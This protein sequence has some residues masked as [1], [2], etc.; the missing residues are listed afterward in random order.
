MTKLCRCAPPLLLAALCSRTAHADGLSAP[1]LAV[2]DGYSSPHF[3]HV[4]LIGGS[5]GV[6][7]AFTAGPAFEYVTYN[8]NGQSLEVGAGARFHVIEP[9]QLYAAAGGIL[10]PLYRPEG[11]GRVTAGLSAQFGNAFFVRPGAAISFGLIGV[12][13]PPT[14]FLPMEA[15]VE[16]GYLFSVFSIYARIAGGLDALQKTTSPTFGR[17]AAGIGI[18]FPIP[19]LEVTT[20]PVL[21]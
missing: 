9:L 14:Y 19:S 2:N 6:A 16:I 11:G 18:E 8:W 4:G 12:K 1:S 17:I 10:Q 20:T 3:M 15:S 21:P 5:D 7:A 13:L